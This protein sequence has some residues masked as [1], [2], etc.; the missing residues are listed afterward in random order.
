MAAKVRIYDIKEAYYPLQ[1]WAKIL[2]Y[3]SSILKYILLILEKN[4]IYPYKKYDKYDKYNNHPKYYI[5]K[6]L[7]KLINLKYKELKIKSKSKRLH[8]QIPNFKKVYSVYQYDQKKYN[9]IYKRIQQLAIKY[10]EN[11][12][13]RVNP[14]N[15]LKLCY[16]K[17]EYGE[18]QKIGDE[19]H[20]Y[21]LKTLQNVLKEIADYI[22]IAYEIIPNE[23]VLNYLFK[24][25][26]VVIYTKDGENQAEILETFDKSIGC[27][28]KVH[29]TLLRYLQQGFEIENAV[30]KT[31]QKIKSR[32]VV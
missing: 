13:Y 12:F 9:S 26:H 6:N 25:T 19:K 17:D 10:D 32:F 24:R 14:Y 15:V 27:R 21:R 4:H 31:I 28:L 22:L 30:H 20:I 5:D 23:D 11:I 3:H 8:Y 18:L 2:G 16:L 29:I 7:Q 1:K